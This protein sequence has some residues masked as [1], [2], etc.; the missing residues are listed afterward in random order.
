MSSP[1]PCDT[2]GSYG[3]DALDILNQAFD[4]AWTEIAGN[5]GGGSLEIQNARTKL[6]AALLRAAEPVGCVDVD[7]LKASI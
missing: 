6:A 5:F 2:D 7:A 1:W 3:P 4:D